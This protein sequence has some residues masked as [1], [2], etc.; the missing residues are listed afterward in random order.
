MA[1]ARASQ[2]AALGVSALVFVA[3]GAA[4]IVWC[5]AMSAMGELAMPG[6][7]TMSMMWMR[8]PGQSW[9]GTAASFLGM[10]MVMMVAMMLPSLI[11]SLWRYRQA[12]EGSGRTRFGWLTALVS[13]GYFSI[14]AM[15]GV[16]VFA[17]GVALVAA[18]VGEPAVARAVPVIVGVVVVIGGIVQ[19]T[20]WKTRRIA[21]CRETP[22]TL[23]DDAGTAVRH[24]LRVGVRCG[25]SCASLMVP[26]LAVGIMDLRA[27]AVVT[28]AITAER[29][30]PDGARAPRI[31]GAVVVAAGAWLIAR[32]VVVG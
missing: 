19:R 10:W 14:W 31:I 28:A 18:A 4:T 7:W 8:M 26:L 27:M 20:M 32:A 3:S 16:V 29:V 17:L 21:S 22:R 30:A 5:S 24:G 25:W 2:H 9:P 12:I 23:P 1:T 11:P 13:L 15:L 6:G